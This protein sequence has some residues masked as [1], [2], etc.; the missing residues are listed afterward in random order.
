MAFQKGNKL[1]GRPKG[2][3]DKKTEQW[4]EFATW[5]MSVGMD[6]LQIEME[7]LEGKDFV[8]TV[9]DLLEYFQPKLARHELTGKG[10]KE[11][12]APLLP[13]NVRDNNSNGK[14][15]RDEQKD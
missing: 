14:D 7:A 9:K 8:Q 10:G 6:R 5:F 12:P 2:S 13:Y 3:K 15:K 1:G 11:L 4:N